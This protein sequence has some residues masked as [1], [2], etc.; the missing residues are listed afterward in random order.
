M[1]RKRRI[2]IEIYIFICVEYRQ[3]DSRRVCLMR[4][5]INCHYF[6]KNISVLKAYFLHKPTIPCVLM[7]FR[8]GRPSSVPVIAKVTKTVFV[9]Q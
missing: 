9:D 5:L 7:F 3:I 6:F 2:F 4:V 8:N 1:T